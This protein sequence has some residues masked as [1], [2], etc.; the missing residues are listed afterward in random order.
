M[1]TLRAS[2]C[3]KFF[4]DPAFLTFSPSVLEATHLSQIYVGVLLRGEPINLSTI[5][6]GVSQKE[7]HKRSAGSRRDDEIL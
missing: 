6:C 7:Q 4:G 1:P 2:Q 3:Q 5:S